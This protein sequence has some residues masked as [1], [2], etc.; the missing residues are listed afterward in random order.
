MARRANRCAAYK[1]QSVLTPDLILPAPSLC[2]AAD[3]A[4]LIMVPGVQI[5]SLAYMPLL[6]AMQRSA[7]VAGL[8]LFAGCVHYDWRRESLCHPDDLKQRVDAIVASL[9]ARG[10]RAEVPCFHAAHSLSTVFLQDYLASH[11]ATAGQILLGGSLLRKHWNPVFSYSVPTLTIGAG[12]DGEEK[13]MR[14]VEQVYAQRDLDQRKFPFVMLEGQT[15][16]QFASGKPPAHMRQELPAA[17][18]NDVAHAA[19]SDVAVDFMRSRL[20]LHGSGATVQK[21]LRSTSAQLNPLLSLSSSCSEWSPAMGPTG[22][23][24]TGVRDD[25]DMYDPDV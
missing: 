23:H 8:S 18:E 3:Q 6:K 1:L 12:L 16:M 11:G 14:Q 10:M 22:I 17:V 24:L 25:S 2:L 4:A 20:G 21:L 7:S 9:V 19:I 15:H 5:D 13:Y